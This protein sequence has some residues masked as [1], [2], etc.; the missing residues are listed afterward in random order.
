MKIAARRGS[1]PSAT[2]SVGSRWCARNASNAPLVVAK[3]AIAS[4]IHLV[5]IV[6][7]TDSQ[8]HVECP[9]A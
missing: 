1:A 8:K 4:M 3:S 5:A 7:S 6:P 9:Q 2:R